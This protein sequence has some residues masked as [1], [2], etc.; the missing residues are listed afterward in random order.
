MQIFLRQCNV[1][2]QSLHK[3]R[4]EWFSR[5]KCFLNLL[6]N[7]SPKTTIH[8][9]FDGNPEPEH[10]INKYLERSQVKI[11]KMQNGGNDSKSFLNMVNYIDEIKHK[12]D[13]DE[14]IYLLEDDYLHL[15]G[16]EKII[17]EGLRELGSPYITLYD[18]P[19]KYFETYPH[20]N[21][22]IYYTKSTHWRTT[23]STTNTYACLLS[24]F[25]EDIDIHREFCDIK[26][27][28]TNDHAKFLSLWQKGK[29]LCSCIPSYST[30]CETEFL[31]PIVKWSEI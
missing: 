26:Q 20:K 16:F 1:S 29:G 5:E 8:V 11:I 25:I 6:D 9:I 23:I 19:D 18:H 12:L 24:T 10:F 7:I 28:W 13:K 30:H 22:H 15:F 31:A 17:E 14:I 4:P 27:G 21:S 3:T 2:K